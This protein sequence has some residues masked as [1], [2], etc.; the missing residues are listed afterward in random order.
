MTE[1]A[2]DSLQSALAYVVEEVSRGSVSSREGLEKVKKRAAVRF[3]L[4]R[5]VSNSEVILALPADARDR[6]EETLRVHPRRSASGIVVVTAFSAPF[7]CPHGTCVFCPGGPRLGTPQSYLPRSPGMKSALSVGFD[8]YQQVRRCLAK[9]GANGHET[10]KVETIIEG[11]TFIAVPADYQA[12]FVKGVYDGLN[13]AVAGSLEEAQEVN[14]GAASRCVGLTLESKPD[15]CRP[16]D[17]D[18]MLSYGITRLEIGVQSLHDAALARSNRGHTVEDSISAFQV[19]RDAG[20]KVTAH[21]MPGLPGATPEEDLED[22]QRL[23]E[24]EAFRPDMSKLYPTLV[25]PGTALERMHGA[26]TYTPYSLET[27]VELLSEMKRFVPRWHRIMRIQREIPADEIAGG[28][29]D[30]NLRQLV[31]DR[32][33]EKG[34]SCRCIRCREV[35]LREPAALS[36]EDRL[37][38]KETTFSASGGEEV[39]GS[40]EFERSGTIAG[41]VR[42]R[43]PSDRA[44]R[45]EV[46]GSAIVRELRVYGKVVRVG[47]RGRAA[48]QHRGLG[49]S[50]MERMERTAAERFGVK[51][52]LVTGAV[53]TRNYYRKLGYERIGPYMGKDLG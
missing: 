1:E 45:P 31:L 19:A 44:H 26:G 15:W 7:S 10:D 43:V 16:Q 6:L 51:R 50:M 37:A 11:G 36:K 18:L 17:I 35:V 12:G 47:E 53:G 24:D 30:G 9:Y 41:F 3:G 5:Y 40:Y 14:E 25:V 33:R 21:M 38:Y 23:F 49:A 28:V 4:N 22:L 20:L 46:A 29:K 48:W 2:F 27:A 13:G 32:A 34:F 8:P 52:L 42:L 39:F